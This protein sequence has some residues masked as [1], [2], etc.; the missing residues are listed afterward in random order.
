MDNVHTTLMCM[1]QDRNYTINCTDFESKITLVN[2]NLIVIKIEE[3]KVGINSVKFV[4][5]SIEDYN[6]N[7][8]IV[9]YNNTITAFA[10][11]SLQTLLD[12]GKTIEFF[13]YNELVYNITKHTLVPQHTLLNNEE[14]RAVLRTYNVPEKKVPYILKTDPVS[15]Y[16]NAQPGQMFKIVRN[17]DVTYKSISYRIVV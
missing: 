16:Y 7:H 5:S 13:L 9:L 11:N 14:K 1:L 17:S 8:A 4:A 12:E 6:V 10:K 3:P 15:R 2:P